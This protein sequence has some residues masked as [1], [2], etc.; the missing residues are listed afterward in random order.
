MD[1]FEGAYTVLLNSS[2][3][4]HW[5]PLAERGAHWRLG[6][7]GARLRAGGIP[8][9]SHTLLGSG[10][11]RYRQS[12]GLG[13]DIRRSFLA[14]QTSG[15]S[16]DS[17][18]TTDNHLIHDK[19]SRQLTECI[20]ESRPRLFVRASKT[21]CNS[22]VYAAMRP[23]FRPSLRQ[24]PRT[25]ALPWPER[26][27]ALLLKN[28]VRRPRRRRAALNTEDERRAMQMAVKHATAE[29]GGATLL[30]RRAPRLLDPTRKTPESGPM[31]RVPRNH[32]RRRPHF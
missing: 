16:P 24:D 25:P 3:I 12:L 4:T 21:F 20:K 17:P 23:T 14:S 27:H 28:G 10:Y 13:E 15:T 22:Q 1:D 18:T 19:W 6:I 26:G 5:S 2:L 32:P 30:E 29:A 11:Q 9:A 7:G 8:A 31:I